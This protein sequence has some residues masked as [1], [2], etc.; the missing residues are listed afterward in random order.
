MQKKSDTLKKLKVKIVKK[1]KEKK[2]EG[3]KKKKKENS[4]E[5]QKPD[6]EI[7]VYN[8]KKCD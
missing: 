3:R 5:Q 7:A 4:T 2:E 1:R 8:N 6:M